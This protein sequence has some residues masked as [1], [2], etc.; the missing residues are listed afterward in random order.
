VGRV[1]GR[2]AR[3]PRVQVGAPDESLTRFSGLAAVTELI[4]RLG[5]IDR[6]DATV[7]PIKVR[8]RGFTAGQVLVGMAAA[9]LCRNWT[10]RALIAALTRL[11][12]A[13]RRLGLLVTPAGA[14]GASSRVSIASGSEQTNG[15]WAPTVRTTS[16]SLDF[17]PAGPVRLALQLRGERLPCLDHLRGRHLAKGGRRWLGHPARSPGVR[18]EPPAPRVR[19]RLRPHRRGP[20]PHVIAAAK[21]DTRAVNGRLTRPTR[22]RGRSEARSPAG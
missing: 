3:R 16:S 4:D 6:L 21:A 22:A 1:R 18:V 8:D 15:A 14:G 5:V 11:L 17:T 9:Q 20:G 2:R 12:R 13:R 10:D 7:G 19:C